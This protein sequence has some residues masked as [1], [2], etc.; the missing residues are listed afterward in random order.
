MGKILWLFSHPF[1][2]STYVARK[3]HALEH[4]TTLGEI[5]DRAFDDPETYFCTDC[6]QNGR[7][8]PIFTE[9][10]L[11]E[12]LENK[13]RFYDFWLSKVD[14]DH[15]C[16]DDK[17]IDLWPPKIDLTT[18]EGNEIVPILLFRNPFAYVFSIYTRTMMEVSSGRRSQPPSVHEIANH[19]IPGRNQTFMGKVDLSKIIYLDFDFFLAYEQEAMD[20]VSLL[21]GIENQQAEHP[22]EKHFVGGN[23]SSFVKREETGFEFDLFHRSQPDA[24]IRDRSEQWYQKA[25]SIPYEYRWAFYFND[26]DMREIL[27]SRYYQMYLN[28]ILNFTNQYVGAMRNK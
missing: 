19:W 28:L 2:G 22:P 12:S 20:Y 10:N 21:A 14:T 13:E 11:Q 4:V 8:C 15:I 9:E 7:D 23:R 26:R 18:V 27:I 25:R 24:T 1:S 16:V 5:Y 3:L 6:R 17:R